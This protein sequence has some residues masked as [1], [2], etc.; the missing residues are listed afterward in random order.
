M[1]PNG[2]NCGMAASNELCPRC[3]TA[4]KSPYELSGDG[5]YHPFRDHDTLYG[6]G[7]CHEATGRIF[8]LVGAKTEAYAVACLLNGHP[9]AAVKFLQGTPGPIPDGYYTRFPKINDRKPV[10]F[11]QDKVDRI[12]AGADGVMIRA[13][14]DG[15]HQNIS[16][17][18]LAKRDPAQAFYRAFEMAM[19]RVPSTPAMPTAAVPLDLL[20]RICKAFRHMNT[21]NGECPDENLFQDID[22]ALAAAD[23]PPP[24]EAGNASAPVRPVAEIVTALKT[25][26]DSLGA[27][28]NTNV[29]APIISVTV[30]ETLRWVLGQE[31]E[32]IDYI[33]KTNTA[34]AR[35]ARSHL[36]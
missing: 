35:Q 30:F 25:L 15:K 5:P 21:H 2:C 4:N 32:H 7:I 20:M 6:W 8:A 33:L 17:A 27:L 12:L 14:V 3:N 29:G 26:T 34:V 28:L 19:S 11:D 31:S 1:T 18:D 10:A 22:K 36:Q 13:C 9:E 24:S 16:L 23:N